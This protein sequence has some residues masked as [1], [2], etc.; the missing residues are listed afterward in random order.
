MP[1]KRE[2]LIAHKCLGYSHRAMVAGPNL[3]TLQAKVFITVRLTS[4]TN[5][6]SWGWFANAANGWARHFV[7]SW[8]LVED[9]PQTGVFT[10]DPEKM[11]DDI[12]WKCL[13]PL[14]PVSSNVGH[15]ITPRR[16]RSRSRTTTHRGQRAGIGLCTGVCKGM[17]SHGMTI[18]L[19]CS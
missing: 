5:T 9:I 12:Q 14:N 4:T 13:G 3:G 16:S 15:C 11:Q 2:S 1:G 10:R 7:L 6:L 19:W 8:Q 18:S 17:V